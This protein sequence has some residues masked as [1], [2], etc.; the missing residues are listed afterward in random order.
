VLALGMAAVAH[1]EKKKIVVGDPKTKWAR[2]SACR[3][4]E[5]TYAD[6]IARSLRSKIVQTGL[7]RVVS[8]EQLKKVLREHEMSMTGLSDP[9]NAKMLGGFL[10]AD[11]VMATEVLCHPNHVEFIVNM[12]DVE[13]AEIVFSKAYEMRNLKKTS[14]AMKDIIKIMKKYAK[15]GE[16]GDAGKSEAMMMIDS[17]AL[18]DASETIITIIERSV[19]SVRATVKDVNVYAETIKVRVR[20]RGWAGMKLKVMR[21]DEEI[22]WL[23]LKKKG[24]GELEAGTTGE[25]SSFEEGDVATSEDF[26][27]KVAVG[28]IEDEDEENEKMVDMFREGLL[29]EMS[30]ADRIEPAD[31]RKIEKIIDRMGSKT[32]KKSLEKLF[33]K[34]V[35]LLITGRFSG[36]AGNRRID[37]EVLSTFDGKRVT[38]IKYDSR[39]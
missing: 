20:G 31:D 10:Q 22:G 36:E 38:K 7:Y 17:K 11:L 27:P 2:S 39:L 5:P 25:M 19:P 12:V 1:A 29:K 8:R 26:K 34:G 33:K 6:T 28:F 14:K 13:T 37:F 3:G 15:T 9:T 18:R 24:S 32:K 16:I 4:Y 35:D 23:Y 30:E 21:D